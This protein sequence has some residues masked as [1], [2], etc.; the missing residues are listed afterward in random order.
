MI[1]MSEQTNK[2][3]G[4]LQ[5][6]NSAFKAFRQNSNALE[7]L[8][9]YG[10]GTSVLNQYVDPLIH[11]K[12]HDVLN[13]WHREFVATVDPHAAKICTVLPQ[14]F[15]C[16]PLKFFA[17]P[18]PIFMN[19][20]ILQGLGLWLSAT[21]LQEVLQIAAEQCYI[22]GWAV[23][24]A[25]AAPNTP[26]GYDFE[27]FSECQL[28]PIDM[29]R[30][31]RNAIVQYHID[32]T[33]LIK[34]R[35]FIRYNLNP[36]RFELTPQTPGI[37]HVEYPYANYGFGLAPL[38]QLWDPLTKLREERHSNSIRKR[39]YPWVRYPRGYRKEDVDKLME[40]LSMWDHANAMATPSEPDNTG[41]DSG[42]P[43]M[44][45]MTPAAS[46][47][48]LSAG[49]GSVFGNVSDEWMSLTDY[50]G[51]S[52]RWF[53]GDPGGAQAGAKVDQ[54]DD[55]MNE[56]RWFNVLQNTLIIPFL[57]LL[58]SLGILQQ[59][60]FQ[61]TDAQ[62]ALIPFSVRT[63]KEY[64]FFAT[65]NYTMQNAMMQDAAGQLIAQNQSSKQ[66]QNALDFWN[67]NEA[68]LIAEGIERENVRGRPAMKF[69]FGN[70]LE[71]PGQFEQALAGGNQ[72]RFLAKHRGAGLRILEQRQQK[73]LDEFTQF[74]MANQPQRPQQAGAPVE[75]Q[76]R[77]EEFFAA[78]Q[79]QEAEVPG[80]VIQTEAPPVQP[81]AEEDPFAADIEEEFDME[82]AEATFT[83]PT[84]QPAP[85]Q[86][87]PIEVNQSAI[88]S[89]QQPEDPNQVSAAGA[90][91]TP[92]TPG[93][94]LPASFG[95]DVSNLS[96]TVE[97]FDIQPDSSGNWADV[98]VQFKSYPGQYYTYPKV[99]YN[100]AM[101][102]KSPT[103]YGQYIWDY[104]RGKIPGKSYPLD[105]RKGQIV[106][107]GTTGSIQPYFISRTAPIQTPQGQLV[108]PFTQAGQ[109]GNIR[110]AVA[111]PAKGSSFQQLMTEREDMRAAAIAYA[112]EDAQTSAP[113]SSNG[114]TPAQMQVAQELEQMLN[115]NNGIRLN[116]VDIATKISL[117]LRSNAKNLIR[118]NALNFTANAFHSGY[119]LWYPE[120]N[121][122]E[123]VCPREIPK[124]VGQK[125]PFGIYHNLEKVNG[126][127][128]P[129]WQQVGWYHITGSDKKDDGIV[130]VANIE[131][132]EAMV[133]HVFSLLNEQDWLTPKIRANEAFEI[134]AAYACDVIENAQGKRLQ[135]NIR[136]ASV[137][138]VP[139]GRCPTGFCNVSKN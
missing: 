89:Q 64:E 93:T 85:I 124:L 102:L 86:S 63:W 106:P 27:I 24:Y 110:G 47:P 56:I 52:I 126:L 130:E 77:Q 90:A 122:L 21:G 7:S 132:D 67:P 81:S 138:A 82:E 113:P 39:I 134:S 37:L 84:P 127:D 65:Q 83:I 120:E 46:A 136:L 73:V 43:A 13:P 72:E 75:P 28:K 100:I 88:I 61:L 1:N 29:L 137:S 111:I 32:Y 96:S 3:P 18:D 125:V 36:V 101:G 55:D 12:Y 70:P 30:D 95:A 92:T 94:P 2:K 11:N 60:G 6:L 33:P 76:P 49:S 42:L 8:G 10:G 121:S 105:P 58:S 87:A 80:S 104:F 114:P 45:F 51:F 59:A 50:T 123:Y 97:N 25:F 91:A 57:Q 66:K 109:Q 115:R 103:S 71:Q 20:E 4:M 54:N 22:H 79:A 26:L 48:S 62:G 78:A 133:N 35:D 15:F 5:R 34:G 38:I 99:P 14:I 74:L 44:Q 31:K 119:G 68:A 17:T 108:T 139:R 128:I 135:T 107:G 19:Q 129:A 98:V 16:K 23:I 112:D 131:L 69:P 116:S 9:I 40:D 53:V 118:N 117:P 41:K